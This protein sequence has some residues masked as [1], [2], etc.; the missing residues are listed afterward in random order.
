MTVL[1]PV[2]S[3]LALPLYSGLSTEVQMS[4]FAPAPADVRKVV[5]STNIAEASLTIDGIVHVVDCGFV[6]LRTFA[7]STG[8]SALTVAPVSKASAQ[9]RAGRA[10]RVRAGVC[11]R[12]YTEDAYEALEASTPP[13]IQRMTLTGV[14]LQLKALGVDDLLHFPFV[15]PPP[16][17]LLLS[18]LDHLYTVGALTSRGV[19]TPLGRDL[20]FLPLDPFI[21][22]ML[23]AAAESD[24]VEEALSIAAMLCIPFPYMRPSTS[25]RSRRRVPLSSFAVEQGDHLTLLNLYSA[26][27]IRPAS[28]HRAFCRRHRLHLP[29]LVQAQHIRS[30]LVTYLGALG[31]PRAGAG[32]A[33][34]DSVLKAVVSGFFH[35]AARRG[36]AGDWRDVRSGL[37]VDVDRESVLGGE[38]EEEE[39]EG[40]DGDWLVYHELVESADRRFMRVVSVIDG[41]WLLEAAP[42]FFTLSTRQLATAQP[43]STTERAAN[44][45]HREL[46]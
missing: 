35:H 37:R 5:V 33:S 22:R 23:L 7:P 40:V 31:R 8:V 32:R 26:F 3:V 11:Y 46:F 45:V 18:A 1:R 6:K 21:G 16:T 25:L 24:C 4:V 20:A 30:Q 9:Q 42:H 19:L 27:S 34:A 29:F 12:L 15:S 39:G 2:R 41:S 43:P 14:V 28:S 17:P 36:P 13:E 44:I 38:E 10:G